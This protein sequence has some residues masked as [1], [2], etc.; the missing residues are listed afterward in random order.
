MSLRLSAEHDK[1]FS[2]IPARIAGIQT[3]RKASEDIHV[4]LDSS[5]PSWNDEI[6]DFLH[7][8]TEAFLADFFKVKRGELWPDQK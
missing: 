4:N 1:E 6:A 3:R 5:A 7:K 2:D 8:F